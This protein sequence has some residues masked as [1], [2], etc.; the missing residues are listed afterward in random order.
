MFFFYSPFSLE[1]TAWL[2][3]SVLVSYTVIIVTHRLYFHP[4]ARFP[5]PKIAAVTKWYEFYMDIMK[6]QGGQFVWEI[7]RM[8]DRYGML[9]GVVKHKV[10]KRSLTCIKALLC[11]ST[12]MNFISAIQPGFKS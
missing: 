3:A 10:E 6:G 11:A 7:D 2:F 5:G 8:H 12:Q 9:C 1:S 4:L